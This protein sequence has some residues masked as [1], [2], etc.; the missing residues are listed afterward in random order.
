M[1]KIIFYASILISFT[2]S[3]SS[4]LFGQQGNYHLIK[5]F[6]NADIYLSK[7]KIEKYIA[8]YGH[9]SLDNMMDNLF[10]PEVGHNKVYIF[11]SSYSGSSLEYTKD[12]VQKFHNIL[13]IMT[14]DNLQIIKAYHYVLEWKE[15]PITYGFSESRLTSKK[16]YLENGLSLSKLNLQFSNG[17]PMI[18]EKPIPIIYWEK[19]R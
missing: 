19:A 1:K 9:D 11:L 10:K 4:L 14:S 15:W 16:I 13:I 2:L 5:Q 12:S 8:R 6:S 17:H 3:S 7:S 18:V